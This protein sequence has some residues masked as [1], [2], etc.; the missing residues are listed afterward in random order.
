MTPVLALYSGLAGAAGG[1][2][3]STGIASTYFIW[4]T[5]RFFQISL[6]EYTSKGLL[7]VIASA[8]SAALIFYLLEKLIVVGSTGRLVAVP[9][10]IGAGVLHLMISFIL[11]LI[12]GGLLPSEKQ[13]FAGRL[14]ALKKQTHSG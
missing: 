2:A 12:S 3:L 13:W 6:T 4:I 8:V 9:I 10:L 1:V 11:L 7:P 5:N 14:H